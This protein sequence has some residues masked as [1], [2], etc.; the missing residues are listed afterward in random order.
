MRVSE[1]SP[2][3]E[4]EN[5]ALLSLFTNRLTAEIRV[6]RTFAVRQ[7]LLVFHPKETTLFP[8]YSL[9]PRATFSLEAM[10]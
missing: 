9:N 4:Q 2:Q 1:L 5:A 8:W 10:R 6:P 7:D 3:E